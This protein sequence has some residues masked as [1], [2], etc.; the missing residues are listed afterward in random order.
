[1]TGDNLY[2][3]VVQFTC[4]PGYDLI[5]VPNVTCQ[6]SATWSG[7]VPTCTRAQCPELTAPADGAM[8]GSNFFEDVVRFTCYAGY[9]LVGAQNATCQAS[10]T[11]SD[12]VPVCS[13][14]PCPPLPPLVNGVQ[15]G[16]SSTYVYGEEVNFQ[17]D[18]G[19]HLLGSS[20]R[21]CLADSTWSGCTP[22]CTD[23]NECSI[24]N[25]GCGQIC[26][27]TFGSFQCSCRIG[28]TLNSDGFA[29][30]DVDEC[31]SANGDCEQICTNTIGSFQCSSVQCPQL[32]A[33]LNG[34]HTAGSSYPTV[35]QFTCDTG[36]NRVGAG[37]IACQADGTWSDSAPTCTL[38]QCPVLRAPTDGTMT[39]SYSYQDVVEFTCDP[40][41]ALSGSAA[42]AVTCQA[43]GT[44]TA[45]APTCTVKSQKSRFC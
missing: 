16:G 35:V 22:T 41:Y 1:M 28:Y 2:Q 24:S 34:G 25:G 6:A 4:E 27:N 7:S 37:S 9:D 8:V 43:D 21:S 14:V 20:L 13:S 30:D 18:A 36:Y 23:I 33:P 19:F 5:G 3:D 42:A 10:A 39:G 12:D 29:C 15:S 17:C 31:A 11:W 40:G 38:A 32:T 26:T 45:P 44:W